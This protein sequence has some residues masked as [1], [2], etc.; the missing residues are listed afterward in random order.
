[1]SPRIPSPP[2][3]QSGLR[4]LLLVA[5]LV[6]VAGGYALAQPPDLTKVR[7]ELGRKPLKSLRTCDRLHTYVVDALVDTVVD[8]RYGNGY[9]WWGCCVPFSSPPAGPEGTGP[10]DF[11]TTNNQEAGVDELDLVKTDGA[12]LYLAQ[13]DRLDIVRSWPAEETAVLGSWPLQGWAEG[14]FLEAERVFVVSTGTGNAELEPGR[15]AGTRLAQV[16]VSRRSS[17]YT[18]R[19]L[20]VEGYPLG[21]RKIGSRVFVVLS[22]AL[23]VP[24]EV[25]DLVWRD[26]LGLPV[27]PH[28]AGDEEREVAVEIAR[29]ILRPEVESILEP[30]DVNDF[31]PLVRSEGPEGQQVSTLLGCADVYRPPLTSS[32]A[33]LS[34]LSLDLQSFELEGRFDSVGILADGLSL[35]ASSRSLYVS[36]SGLSWWWGWRPLDLET[37]IHRFELSDD[38]TRPVRYAASGTVSGFLLDQFSM[39]EWQG[40]LRVASTDFGWWPADTPEQERGN[41]ITVLRDDG[42]GSLQKIGQVGG[43][44]PGEQ[45]FASR[46]M[47]EKGYLVTFEQIDPLFTL[48]LS[49]PTAPRVVGELE[50]PGFS[51]YLHP[52]GEDHLLAVGRTGRPDGTIEGLAV[53]LFDVSDFT[54]PELA[55]QEAVEPRRGWAWSEALDDHRAFTYHRDV[56]SIPASY[57]IGPGSV[58]F[59]GLLVYQI[60]LEHGIQELGRIDHSGFARVVGG[61]PSVR[62]SVYIDDA[63]YSISDQG[64]KV[65]DLHQPDRL[66]AEVPLP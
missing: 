5:L 24:S 15:W 19:S 53:N 12:Y 23:P 65:N 20:E 31:L 14:L 2:S 18:V 46:F 3:L 17:P 60:D 21:A 52:I 32:L 28:D 43:I 54:R 45:I 16:D 57:S 38:P 25:W 51:T 10:G 7:R 13:D 66:L 44:A 64:I 49:D 8:A 61:N 26:D 36:Q 41:R 58:T 63:I 4:F 50:M 34:V 56:L 47:G 40:D 39:G 29:A 27:L 55:F 22:S 11:T 1:M 33:V 30:L 48:D 9:G 37:D 59:S 62:R 6:W 42:R 35:Y